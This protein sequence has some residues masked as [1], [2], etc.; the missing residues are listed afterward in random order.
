[1]REKIARREV[2]RILGAT[3]AGAW[4]GEPFLH[5]TDTEIRIA[6]KL[7][8]V[9]VKVFSKHTV[10]ITIAEQTK[11]SAGPAA[12]D[13][14]LVNP[15]SSSE[16]FLISAGAPAH[17]APSGDALRVRVTHDPLTIIVEKTDGR[18][19]QKLRIDEASGSVTF[20]LGEG[21]VLG[22]GEGGPQ[23][24]RRGDVDQMRSG[25]GGYRLRTNGGRVPIQWLIGTSGWAM[26]IHHPLGN[27]DLSG[28]EGFFRRTQTQR[29]RWIFL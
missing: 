18:V 10:R 2:L 26:F 9:S 3:A 23:F 1:M 27:F 5:A 20:P 4:I 13:G 29:C 8:N 14:A 25:Q 6:G 7:A 12:N 15:M 24:D 11:S 19:V 28:A 21:P 17:A 22:L 16:Q